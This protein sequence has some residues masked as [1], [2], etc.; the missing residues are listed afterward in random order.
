MCY[1]ALGKNGKLAFRSRLV[2]PVSGGGINKSCKF[3]KELQAK[4]L[5][6]IVH[7]PVCG[8]LR[9]QAFRKLELERLWIPISFLFK[10]IKYVFFL[11][12]WL[13]DDHWWTKRDGSLNIFSI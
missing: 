7:L 11:T 13:N 6:S 9:S 4:G 5:I 8:Y 10:I 2:N 1:L 3:A 12:L